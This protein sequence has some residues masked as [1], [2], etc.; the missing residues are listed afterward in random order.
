MTGTR[1]WW[2]HPALRLASSLALLAL[3]F[4][5]LDTGAVLA[6]LARLDPAWLALALAVG[7]LQVL[8]SAWR[9][10]FTAHCLGLRLPFATALR[11]YYLANLLNQVLPGGILGD[12]ARAWRHARA[13]A[14]AGPA[15]RAVVLERA[16]GQLATVVL[17]IAALAAQPALLRAGLPP[18][19]RDAGLTAVAGLVLLAGVG[20]GCRRWLR[21]WFAD[22]RRALLRPAVLPIQLAASLAVAGSYVLVFALGAL[23]VGIGGAASAWLPLIPLVL[24][25]MLIPLGVAGWGLRE[26]AAALLWPLAGLPAA[27]G[28]AASVT[29]GLL[30]LIGSLPGALFLHRRDG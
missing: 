30:V 9:W 15:V 24:L 23:A 19:L 3:V 6:R 22:A 2:R 27:D 4:S 5:Q 25:A 17:V 21:P 16:S 10:R 1:R 18:G 20:M 28:V 7:V 13:S 8:L 12:A 26:G 11:E 14:R 29:Y